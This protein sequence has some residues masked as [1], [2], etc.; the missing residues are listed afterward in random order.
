MV[1]YLNKHKIMAI[2]V[3]ISLFLVGI[4]LFYDN[5][6]ISSK[7]SSENNKYIVS[8][9]VHGSSNGVGESIVDGN[10]RTITM[11]VEKFNLT[12]LTIKLIW[13]DNK[14]PL[15]QTAEVTLNL[16]NANHDLVEEIKGTDGSVG[17]SIDAGP[18]NELPNE[19]L[20]S[21]KNISNAWSKVLEK[22]PPSSIG[23]CNWY[24]TISVIRNGFTNPLNP[25]SID[26]DC[27]ADYDLYNASIK[28]V[29]P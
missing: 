27:R 11:E 4:S 9:L 5:K 16:K 1:K 6:N 18:L 25:G 26:F 17:L 19:T 2:I 20:I 14:P 3:I 29:N 8:F 13:R 12:K 28:E 7:K 24:V 23:T 15:G 10:T 22:F 21:A